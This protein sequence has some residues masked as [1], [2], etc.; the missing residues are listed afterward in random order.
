MIMSLNQC[1]LDNCFSYDFQDL[2]DLLWPNHINFHE[3]IKTTAKE[4]FKDHASN[5]NI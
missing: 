2:K 4:N 5:Q 3:V 1:I